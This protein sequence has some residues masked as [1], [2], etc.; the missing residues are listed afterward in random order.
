MFLSL[1]HISYL[2]NKSQFLN[3]N[4]QKIAPIVIVTALVD[5]IEV[6]KR[7]MQ[8]DKDLKISGFTSW[9]GKTS[10]ETTMRL[11]QV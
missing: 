7:N 4:N 6:K 3:L 1:V 9:V 5:R 10:S 8:I 2:H 11:E